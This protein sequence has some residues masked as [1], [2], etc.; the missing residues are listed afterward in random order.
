MVFHHEYTVTN[1]F[2]PTFFAPNC[3]R[4]AQIG[5]TSTSNIRCERAMTATVVEPDGLKANWSSNCMQTWRGFW[6]VG[7]PMVTICPIAGLV[8][9]ST[10]AHVCHATE[11]GMYTQIGKVVFYGIRYPNLRGA[12]LQRSQI[13]GTAIYIRRCRLTYNDQIRHGNPSREGMFSGG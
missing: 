3:I 11:L 7:V 1:I 6:S 8:D 12:G 13:F 2:Y 10:H 5:S 4:S 9:L